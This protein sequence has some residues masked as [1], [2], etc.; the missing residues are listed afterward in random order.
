MLHAA[1]PHRLTV[2]TERAPTL[3]A[4]PITHQLS[5]RILPP[6]TRGCGGATNSGPSTR[7]EERAPT[8]ARAEN[9][10]AGSNLLARPRG[11]VAL[12][13]CVEHHASVQPPGAL[14]SVALSL[15]PPAFAVCIRTT[16][17]RPPFKTP[18]LASFPFDRR[19]PFDRCAYTALCYLSVLTYLQKRL[20]L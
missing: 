6:V 14:V 17:F 18:L 15:S 2:P 19:A 5:P 8:R 16:P 9:G 12:R 3:I 20:F 11:A 10:T 4:H 1:A 13:V 7:R